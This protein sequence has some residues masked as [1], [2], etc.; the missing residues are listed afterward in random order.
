MDG[1]DDIYGYGGAGND[2]I[3]GG[4]HTNSMVAF[5]GFGDDKIWAINPEQ[6]G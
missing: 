3:I 2:K 6:R 4:L 5:G 1:S